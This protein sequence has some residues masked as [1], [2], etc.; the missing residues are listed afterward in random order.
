MAL[1]YPF[2]LMVI[3]FY[4][5]QPPPPTGTDILTLEFDFSWITEFSNSYCNIGY[6][7]Q[8]SQKL[9]H[10]GQKNLGGHEHFLGEEVVLRQKLI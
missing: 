6:D 5:Q 9:V 7:V 4:I 10:M 1:G 3:M 8:V 2:G